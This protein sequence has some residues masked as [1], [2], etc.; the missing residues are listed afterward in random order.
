VRKHR[1]DPTAEDWLWITLHSPSLQFGYASIAHRFLVHLGC[2][3]HDGTFVIVSQFPYS[4]WWHRIK[5]AA[6]VGFADGDGR[7]FDGFIWQFS[8]V[9][10]DLW[11]NRYRRSSQSFLRSRF[12]LVSS[13]SSDLVMKDARYDVG[14][15][16]RFWPNRCR[17]IGC[18]LLLLFDL[19]ICNGFDGTILISDVV[20]Q[21]I[22]IIIRLF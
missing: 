10:L 22:M 21:T 15:G 6:R 12:V 7:R 1:V 17:T 5:P 13:G 2:E 9:W 19:P 18:I 4:G 8:F 20:E 14:F 16:T 3:F 11:L